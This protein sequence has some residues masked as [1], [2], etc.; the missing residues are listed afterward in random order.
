MKAYWIAFVTVVVLGFVVLGWAGYRIYQEKPPIPDAGRHHGRPTGH[1]QR[2]DQRRTECL[3]GDGRHG[4]GLDLGTRQLRGARLDRRLAAPRMRVHP[5]PLV[6][7][8][9]GGADFAALAAEQQAVLKSR[10]ATIMRTNTFDPSTGTIDI[11]SRPRG[12][13]R[14]NLAHYADVFSNGNTEYSIPA[15]RAERPGE[16]PPARGILLLDLL[17]GL[18]Q[19]SRRGHHLH[20][21]LAARRARRQPSHSRRRRVDRRQHH[22]AAGR[23]RRHGLVP[24][25]PAESEPT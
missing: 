21:Q 3:A 17:G 6:I 8:N 19:P 9:A 23:D 7:G 25:L 18:D 10:L 11:D 13:V 20:Q 22:P 24:C 15:R 16:A 1:R 14:G 12:S 2:R 5:R 4:N